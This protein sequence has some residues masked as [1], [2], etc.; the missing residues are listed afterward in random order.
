MFAPGLTLTGG[1]EE[2]RFF[3]DRHLR[4]RV[5]SVGTSIFHADG[6]FGIVCHRVLEA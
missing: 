2:Y 4:L 3:P 5:P 6:G 1:D